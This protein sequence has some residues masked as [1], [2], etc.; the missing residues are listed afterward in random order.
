LAPNTTSKGFRP[1]PP[2]IDEVRLERLRIT[3]RLAGWW[4]ATQG[5]LYLVLDGHMAGL[6]HLRYDD[7]LAPYLR[8]LALSQLCLGFFLLKSMR[9]PRR[10]YLAVDVLILYLMG[11]VYFVLAYRLGYNALTP[12]EWVSGLVDLG[13]TVSLVLHRTRSSQMKGA[14]SLLSESALDLAHE[15]SQWI[16]KKGPA[17]RPSLGEL[18]AQAPE[19]SSKGSSEAIPHLD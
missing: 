10:Q 2:T 16:Q 3:V 4:L 6:L 13:L 12:F 14:G 5:L 8:M 9:D 7:Y 15:T 17:P 1:A 11:H 18:E 19:R